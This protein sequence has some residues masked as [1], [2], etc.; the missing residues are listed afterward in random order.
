VSF[1]DIL[2][3]HDEWVTPI[4][5][6][7]R[8]AYEQG[9]VDDG[10][11]MEALHELLAAMLQVQRQVY[12]EA[13]KLPAART[14]TR[15]ELYRQLQIGRDFIHD[16]LQESVSLETVAQAAALSPYHFL[17][18]FKQLYGQTP[19][20][21]LTAQRLKRAKQLLAQTDMPVTDICFEVGFQSLGSFSALFQRHDG[22]SPS[23]FRRQNSYLTQ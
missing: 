22:R 7:L 5:Q 19:H 15:K 10:W 18:S 21:Y 14:A 2:H 9:M 1:F 11:Q 17:R 16:N 20:A 12:Q 13:A 8:L 6:R 3:R 4:L 23:Q